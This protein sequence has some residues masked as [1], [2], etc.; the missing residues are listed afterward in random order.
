MAVSINADKIKNYKSGVFESGFFSS[1]KTDPN[2]W[3]TLV[4][5]GTLDGKKYW[6]LKNS[7][8]TSWG[9]NGYL[10]IIRKGD[11]EGEC[12]VQHEAYFTR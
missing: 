11:G 7:M 3:M 2:H 6:K 5:Y 10:L 4:G 12:G 1:C 8:G 9:V